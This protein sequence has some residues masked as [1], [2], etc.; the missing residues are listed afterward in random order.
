MKYK[1]RW[2]RYFTITSVLLLV[3]RTGWTQPTPTWLVQGTFAAAYDIVALDGESAS[4]IGGGA[5]SDGVVLG[6]IPLTGDDSTSALIATFAGDA[7][8]LWGR[9]G[10]FRVKQGG[11]EL[12]GQLILGFEGAVDAL[13]NIYTTEGYMFAYDSGM[14]TSG[15]VSI[16]K[17]ASDG[18]PVWTVP[19]HPPVSDPADQPG[20][21]VG[22]GADRAGNLYTAGIYRD[23]L[24]LAPDT[25]AAFPLPDYV[26]DVF[27][28]SYTSDGVLRWSRRM[29]GPGTDVIAAWMDPRGAFAVDGAGNTYLG[30]FFSQGAVFGEGQP[31][32]VT[33]PADA[34]ALASYDASG[35]LA[36]VRTA[37]DLGISDNA[38]PW[39]LAVDTK[40]NLF[41]DWFVLSTGGIN[42]VTVGDTT[43]TDP[44]FGGEFLTKLSPDGSILWARQLKSDGN[45][46][47]SDLTTDAQGHV[48]VAGK[49]DGLSLTL[50]GEELRK[51]DLQADKEDGFVAHYDAEGRLRWAGH[52]AGEDFQRINAIAVSAS[53]DLYVAGE[54][55]Q[56]LHLGGEVLEAQAYSDLFVAKYAAATIT[57]REAPAVAPAQLRLAPAYPN[58]FRET[59]TIAYEVP[60]TGPVR[61][62]VYDVLGR[63]VAVL[64]EGLQPA[65]T[66][67][68]TFSAHDLPSGTYLYRLTTPRGSFS[69]TIVLSK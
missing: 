5:F 62:A 14:L 20:F 31:G 26:G 43:F 32:A 53:G 15:G 3:G 49:F 69:K 58:P 11:T 6:D 27:L 37:A 57:A 10:A 7:S 55:S 28:A 45:E 2:G 23:T 63:E 25:L 36:W 38:G 33:F 9:Q 12:L 47:I 65:G 22:L 18:T 29:G 56:T 54:F 48:Y 16:N 44:G 40:G 41:V 67:Q 61:L 66:H 42:T 52:A 59:T 46:I 30:G 17:Y 4:I 68:V 1:C 21:A 34:Y 64:A 39:R 51:Q 60:E 19:L 24:I 35:Q 8:F 50:E 13:G